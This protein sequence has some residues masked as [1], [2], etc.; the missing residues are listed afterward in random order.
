M[1]YTPDETHPFDKYLM[2][3]ARAVISG[4]KE[5]EMTTEELLMLQIKIVHL[6]FIGE[7]NL[8]R[9]KQLM[10]INIKII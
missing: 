3:F 6:G 10:G 8:C 1:K 5:I 7:L 2:P 4:E 9:D